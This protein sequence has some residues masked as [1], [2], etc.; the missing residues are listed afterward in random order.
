MPYRQDAIG[1]NGE[2]F[3]AQQVDYATPAPLTTRLH[4]KIG[5]TLT[6][7]REFYVSEEPTP[8]R[9]RTAVTEISRSPEG[10]IPFD[11]DTNGMGPIYKMTLCSDRDVIT[12]PDCDGGIRTQ[13][14][15]DYVGASLSLDCGF[16][17][18]TFPAS[19]SLTVVYRTAGDPK[20]PLI[21]VTADYASYAAGVFTLVAALGGVSSG[22]VLVEDYVFLHDA[23][24][25][26]GT[27]V[28][29][30]EAGRKLETVSTL[31]ILRDIVMFHY[32]GVKVE[33]LTETFARKQQVTGTISVKGSDSFFGGILSANVAIGDTQLQ[34]FDIDNDIRD[35][36]IFYPPT[37]SYTLWI[38]IESGITFTAVSA[39]GLVTGIPAA[40]TGSITSTHTISPE[41]EV[42]GFSSS[43]NIALNAASD[44]LRSFNA[45][46]TWRVGVD[47]SSDLFAAEVFDA[48]YTIA[49][50]LDP[51]KV[52]LGGGGRVA[53]PEGIRDVTGKLTLEF[54]SPEE[55]NR[56][57]R[58]T[59]MRLE[60]NAVDQLRTIASTN[61]AESNDVVFERI[62][63]TGNIPTM[64]DL[65]TI[66]YDLEWRALAG[67]NKGSVIK[68][69][70]NGQASAVA[71]G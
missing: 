15:V 23:V 68:I 16:I 11:V 22:E 13:A 7:A 41:R 51:E 8:I 57:R 56:V 36:N 46:V 42:V 6:P 60:I 4:F 53:L 21:S 50:N 29:I 45:G 52:A 31:G 9:D 48:E 20:Q 64:N 35:S 67:I 63:F 70:T 71:G 55:M 3:W 24:A 69:V 2:L 59:E 28:H 18:A 49:N 65:A 1:A 30:Y 47:T 19:G 25:F 33:S 44:P 62:H 37:G 26:A 38:G 14:R 66:Y 40:G 54:D 10:D 58:G 12:I 61:V 39:T 43:P 32:Y 27:Y 34:L 5:E 17:P